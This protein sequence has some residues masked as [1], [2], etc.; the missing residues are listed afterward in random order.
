MSD[1]EMN[2]EEKKSEKLILGDELLKE[3]QEYY[4]TFKDAL[5]AASVSVVPSKE[6]GVVDISVLL[7]DKSEDSI[8]CLVDV[9]LAIHN[10]D[11][12]AIATQNLYTY[13]KQ[14]DQLDAFNKFATK[15]AKEAAKMKKPLISPI[16]LGL[17]YDNKTD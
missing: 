17:S 12:F 11:F 14:H 16:M 13:M 6:P 2:P 5:P 3:F 15:F 1:Q 10:K 8:E 7:K 4:E 9:M